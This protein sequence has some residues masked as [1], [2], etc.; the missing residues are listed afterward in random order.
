M[1]SA[2]CF[3][4]SLK[5]GDIELI[6]FL[7]YA[8]GSVGEARSQLQLALDRGYIN[9]VDFERIYDMLLQENRMLKGFI[10]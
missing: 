10:K 6:Q 2:F 1:R 5:D 3:L 8:E 9:Q 4:C 7:L